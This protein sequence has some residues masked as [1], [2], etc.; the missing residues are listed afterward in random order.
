[1]DVLFENV[2]T[3]FMSR[4]KIMGRRNKTLKINRKINPRKGKNDEKI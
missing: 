3:K 1:M 4:E 2:P